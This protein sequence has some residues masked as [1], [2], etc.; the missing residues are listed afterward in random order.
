MLSKPILI[1][2]ALGLL[3]VVLFI[4]PLQFGGLGFILAP[5]MSLP[6]FVSVLGFGTVTGI[7]SALIAAIAMGVIGGP[8]AAL[9]FFAWQLLPPLWTGYMVGLSRDDDGPVEWFPLST[10]LFRI[11]LLCGG[12][13]FIVEVSTGFVATQ[14]PIMLNDMVEQ[15]KAAGAAGNAE[16]VQQSLDFITRVAPFTLPATLIAF[17]A[18][19]FHLGSKIARGQGWMLRPRDFLPEAVGLP[20]TAIGAFSAALLLAVFGTGI[21]E[22]GGKM[23][24][25]ALGVAFI[26]VGLATFHALLPVSPGRSALLIFTYLIL[27]F[28]TPAIFG[29]VILGIVETLFQLRARRAASPPNIPT[30]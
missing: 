6:L 12:L 15:T 22:I 19:N 21:L 14:L 26:F 9:L 2:I 30:T 17:L 20:M 18:L 28:I 24:T 8:L 3:T 10:V 29:F 23:F 25:G 5:F 11:S 16:S 7:V 4:S 27:L 13:M 1:A